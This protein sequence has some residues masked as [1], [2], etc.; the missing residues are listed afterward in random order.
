MLINFGFINN[1]EKTGNMIKKIILS[2]FY[3]LIG[4]VVYAQTAD[5]LIIKDSISNLSIKNVNVLLP[6]YDTTLV[7][8]TAGVVDLSGFSDIDTLIV[9]KFGYEQQ[10]L[11]ENQ[12]NILLKKDKMAYSHNLKLLDLEHNEGFSFIKLSINGEI[13]W[14]KQKVGPLFLGN[15]I[16]I[17]SYQDYANIFQNHKI[18]KTVSVDR[19]ST[20]LNSSH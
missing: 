6:K 14:F 1:F 20:R 12:R 4:I 10:I 5:L 19:K 16:E 15:G 17:G 13:Y 7:S 3:F 9:K 18:I 11:T 2:F 8:D